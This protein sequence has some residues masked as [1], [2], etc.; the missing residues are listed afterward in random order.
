MK[1]KWNKIERYRRTQRRSSRSAKKKTK[2][3]QRNAG[4]PRILRDRERSR[5]RANKYI[6]REKAR[7]K[8]HVGGWKEHFDGAIELQRLCFPWHCTPFIVGEIS[9]GRKFS[10]VLD[11][12]PMIWFW[13]RSQSDVQLRCHL[14]EMSESMGV[15]CKF[16]V[17]PF[18]RCTDIGW[19]MAMI[20][21]KRCKIPLQMS[22]CSPSKASNSMGNS[23]ALYFFSFLHTFLMSMY[24]FSSATD[25]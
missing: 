23:F 10:P 12:K 5:G 7:G 3:K 1:K 17:V 11:E 24:L 6:E 19:Q 22:L 16:M 14:I 15:W 2:R 8:K 13:S 25:L 4:V 20:S 9:N 18:E 21:V